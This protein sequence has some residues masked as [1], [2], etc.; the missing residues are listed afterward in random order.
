MSPS[1]TKQE[2]DA[3]VAHETK[4]IQP[5]L[6]R[7]GFSLDELQPQTVGERYLTRP[8]GGGRKVVFLGRRLSD[9]IRVV[10]KTSSE[11][12]GLAELVLEQRA[13]DMLRRIRF[14]YG[15][16]SLPEELAFDETKGVLITEY[17]DQEKPFLDR[18]LKEQFTIALGAFKAQEGAHAT[19]TEHAFEVADYYI[20]AEEY[21]K[22]GMYAQDIVS[23][24]RDDAELYVKLKVLLDDAVEIIRTQEE[25]LERYSGF[26]THWDFI[27]QNFRIRNGK[28]YLLDLASVRFGNKYEGWARFINF[29]TLY[30]PP[31]ADAL[32]KYV[33]LN[34]TK[35]ELLSLKL[36]RA[37]RLV[38]LIRY[39][40]SWLS[41][42]EGDTRELARARIAFW[43]EV[44]D[45][46]LTDRRISDQ[47]IGAYKAR[48]DSLRSDDE[49]HRQKDLH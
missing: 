13:R 35:E 42:T 11:A 22:I 30:N 2:W 21:K 29:M 10:I 36:M 32:V 34:R 17:I 23:F 45:A 1:T 20:E 46:V 48:R 6:E 5:L 9:G 47:T 27:P 12:N 37:Y 44:L 26:L 15:V 33:R 31:L 14:A 4:R 24:L 16:F 43:T 38:E 28:V 49:K 8:V 18:P 40:A 41:R 39:Y 7:T 25:T 19:T 3:Y